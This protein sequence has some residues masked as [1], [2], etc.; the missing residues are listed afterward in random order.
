[1][2]SAERSRPSPRIPWQD[3]AR[4]AGSDSAAAARLISLQ[5]DMRLSPSESVD[6]ALSRRARPATDASALR[7]QPLPL[8]ISAPTMHENP[9]L[10][11][12]DENLKKSNIRTVIFFLFSLLTRSLSGEKKQNTLARGAG[13]GGWCYGSQQGGVTGWYP[14]R[15][16][17]KGAERRSV[18]THAVRL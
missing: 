14:A 15:A 2:R 1:M 11:G 7:E 17:R 10:F 12:H 8:T 16:F 18:L 9:G 5:I 13:G 3:C 4:V 6:G